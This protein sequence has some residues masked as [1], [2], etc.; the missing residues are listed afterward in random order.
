LSF[1]PCLA[2][3]LSRARLTTIVGIAAGFS[4][5]TQGLCIVVGGSFAQGFTGGIKGGMA[6]WNGCFCSKGG[7]IK[8][9]MFA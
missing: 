4:F 2:G 9:G 6:L 8:G 5:L 3:S 1:E 7:G